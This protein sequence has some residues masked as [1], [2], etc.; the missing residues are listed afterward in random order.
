[1]SYNEEMAPIDS[2]DDY[3][4]WETAGERILSY[5]VTGIRLKKNQKINKLFLRTPHTCLY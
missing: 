2:F 4:Q 3:S 5:D 1:M